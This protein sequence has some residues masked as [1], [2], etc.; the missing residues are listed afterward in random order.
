YWS[1]EGCACTPIS[2]WGTP[3]P[4]RHR[5]ISSSA[6]CCSCRRS[7][8]ATTSNRRPPGERSIERAAISPRAS[9]VCDRARSCGETALVIFSSRPPPPAVLGRRDDRCAMFH[10]LGLGLGGLHP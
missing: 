9:S 6:Y 1:P 8:R 3:P 2:S 4:R 10:G 7:C 5:T